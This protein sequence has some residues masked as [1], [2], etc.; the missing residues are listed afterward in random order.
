M[1]ISL[2]FIGIAAAT[3]VLGVGSATKG[4]SD[5]VKAN[6]LNQNTD[7]RL[8]AAKTRLEE[9]R[10]QCG[11]VLVNL[12]SEK[13]F[14]LTHSIRSFVDSFTKIKNVDLTE[15][16]ELME[17]HHLHVDRK[18]FEELTELS[19]FSS[20]LLTGTAA[21]AAGGALT[22][23]GAYSAAATFATAST[24]T[25]IGS[26]SGAAASNATLA[27]FGGGSLA[28]GGMGMAGGA[29]VLGGLV[30]GPAL[31]V[32]GLFV[33]AKGGKNLETAKINA[34]EATE[35][36]EQMEAGAVQCVAIRRRTM[37]FYSLLAR[38][39]AMFLP[40]IHG[41][42]KVI[43]NEGTDYSRYTSQSKKA[44]A[45]AASMAVSVK[46]VLDTPLLTESGELTD[47]SE[48]V[49]KETAER[50]GKIELI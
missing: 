36:C 39:D 21:G 50:I 37:M 35:A 42:E 13:L 6:N 26:L 14:V 23:F 44:I 40:L 7:E 3:G 9:L 27:C 34:A 18:E 31:M 46:A 16:T 28:S 41:M 32:M 19:S 2:L 45:N 11:D 24:G 17:M 15:T 1:S 8:E 48:V 29:A 5:Q 25:A 30:A 38:L 47:Q 49:S 43:E 20:S 4:V 33:G 10:Q 12:G 22:A